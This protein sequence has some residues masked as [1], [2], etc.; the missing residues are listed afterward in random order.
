[1]A[2]T[3]MNVVPDLYGQFSY[4]Y[5]DSLSAAGSGKSILIPAGVH[6][7]AVTAQAAGGGTSVIVYTS[8]DS[9]A[10][11]EADSAVTWIAWAA[12][13]ITTA[14]AS[15]FYPVTAIKIIQTGTGTSSITVRAQ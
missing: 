2:Y 13:A 1:M 4:Q 11:V 5:T 3:R 8:T 15:T 6:S 10:V 14:T 12:G 9:L 7:V